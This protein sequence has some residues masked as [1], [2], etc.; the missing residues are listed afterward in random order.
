MTRCQTVYPLKMTAMNELCSVLA[1]DSAFWGFPVARLNATTLT[2]DTAARACQW[3]RARAIRCLQFAACGTCPTT[4]RVADDEGFRFVDVRVELARSLAQTTA[5][6]EPATMPVRRAEPGDC[7]RLRNLARMAHR[8]TRFFK[9]TRFDQERSA[10]LYAAWI[11]RD[12]DSHLVL[13]CDR[14]EVL[15]GIGG[16]VTCERTLQPDSGRIGLLAVHP[17]LR[18]E[19][20][21]RGLVAAAAEHFRRCGVSR[22]TVATQGTNVPALRLYEQMGFR[23]EQVSVWF[24]KW[25]G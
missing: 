24:H 15:S 5:T 14:P 12:L 17:R 19:G 4:L 16:Y 23:V 9:D 21:G 8:D 2:P 13:A 10:E 18:G 7:D 11:T 25:F 3:C 22:L 1:W 6:A 20:I